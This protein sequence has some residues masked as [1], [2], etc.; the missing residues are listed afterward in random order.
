MTD[1]EKEDERIAMEAYSIWRGS[2]RYTK[3]V[4]AHWNDLGPQW[5][6]ALLFLVAH[7]R[8]FEIEQAAL[9]KSVNK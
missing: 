5:Q 7:A 1:T 6:S 3:F 8:H 9:S 4:P 2:H